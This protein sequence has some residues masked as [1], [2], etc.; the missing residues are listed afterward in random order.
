MNID[1]YRLG[2]EFYFRFYEKMI[3]WI[4]TKTKYKKGNGEYIDTLNF[5]FNS[6]TKT[7]KILEKSYSKTALA[8][9]HIRN[10]YGVGYIN[11]KRMLITNI[12]GDNL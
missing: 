4:V 12:F 10:S 11:P 3:V 6:K 8:D 7:L 5:E 9:G 1:L 2:D